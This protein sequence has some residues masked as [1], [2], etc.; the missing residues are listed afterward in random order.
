MAERQLD[1]VFASRGFADAL[2]VRALNDPEEWGQSDHCR[3]EIKETGGCRR[4]HPLGHRAV[5]RAGEAGADVRPD[6]DRNDEASATSQAAEP[7]PVFPIRLRPP[8]A[9]AGV[10]PS[11]AAELRDWV[12][13]N[14]QLP[15]D[16]KRGTMRC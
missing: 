5:P 16:V 11:T 2:S 8:A 14:I 6:Q 13:N 10:A 1:Y 9:V 4:G 15:P 3:I 7:E 12:L